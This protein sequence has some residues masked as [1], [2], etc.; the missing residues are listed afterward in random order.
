MQSETFV[1]ERCLDDPSLLAA[2]VDRL[3]WQGYGIVAV[4]PRQLAADGRVESYAVIAQRRAE[5]FLPSERMFLDL[6]Q[7]VAVPMH[8]I[9]QQLPLLSGSAVK[10]WLF[11]ARHVGVSDGMDAQ[12]SQSQLLQGV[13]GSDGCFLNRGAGIRDRKTL[14]TA[15]A[16]LEESGL[17]SRTRRRGSNDAHLATQYTIQGKGR[18]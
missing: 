13:R 12:L 1:V 6:Q 14:R 2:T 8:V 3:H 18:Y 16:Q 17:V 4:T 11:L 7:M 15:L 9:D 5:G 10:L